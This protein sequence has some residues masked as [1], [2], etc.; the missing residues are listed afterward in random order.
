MK[1]PGLHACLQQFSS[2]HYCT[3]L[4]RHDTSD[5]TLQ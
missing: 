5:F 3:V 1:I 2:K 4:A